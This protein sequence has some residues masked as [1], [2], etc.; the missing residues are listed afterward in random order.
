MTER[1][2]DARA[3]GEQS[4]PGEQLRPRE[5]AGVEPPHGGNETAGAHGNSAPDAGRTRGPAGTGQG[6]GGG[7]AEV[8]L[9]QLSGDVDATLGDDAVTEVKPNDGAK[10]TERPLGA[11][12]SGR[13]DG[14]RTEEELRRSGKQP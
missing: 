14:H 6:G 7:I 12:F 1:Q 11:D 13:R 8:E 9:E 4:G 10:P 5:D 2:Q 3:D